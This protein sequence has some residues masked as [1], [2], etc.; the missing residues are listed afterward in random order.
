MASDEQDRLIDELLKGCKGPEEILG[1]NGLLKRMNARFMERALNGELTEHLGYAPHERGEEPRTNSRNGTSPKTVITESGAVDL[2]VPRDR[3]GSFE[4]VLVP[5]GQRR[6]EGFDEKVIALY[7][8]GLT[9]REIQAHLEELYAVEVSPALISTVTA[10]VAEDVRAWQTRR[11]DPL[12]PVI[13]FDALFVK[14][15]QEG[16][17]SSRAVYLALAIDRHGRKDLLGL[18][19]AATEGAKFWLNVLTELQAR[20]LQDCFVACVDGLNGFG[21][22]LQAVFPRTSVQLCIVHKVRNSLRLVPWKQRKA[23][24]EDLRAIYGAATLEQAQAALE[25]FAERWDA[26][27]PLISRSW[28]KDWDGLTTF[29]DYPPQIRKVLYTTNAIESLNYSL[30]RVLKNRGAFPDDA[31]VIKILHL[32][33]ARAARKWTMPIH[34]WPDAVNRFVIM[35][36]DRMPVQ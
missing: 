24:A 25:Q 22:A 19:I 12:Y 2:K 33:I 8:R 13:Y 15:R 28:R 29:F 5:K 21:E 14:T 6:L 34:N 31:S 9:T 23:V 4:P 16:P 11:L 20:G 7:A 26:Q 10:E 32:A 30:R 18:W 27:Y 1:K 36:G 3:D 17:A 35:F